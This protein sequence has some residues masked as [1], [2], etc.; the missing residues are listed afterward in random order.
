M[1]P[2]LLSPI[3]IGRHIFKN[4]IVSAP[5]GMLPVLP[6]FQMLGPALEDVKR[7]CRGGIAEFIV[8]ETPIDSERSR[9][10]A[11][12]SSDYTD[13]ES[14]AAR[15]FR[16][17]TDAMHELGVVAMIELNHCGAA[18]DVGGPGMNPIGP[19]GFIR[20]DGIEVEEMDEQMMGRVADNFATCV[21]F[22]QTV[23]F[24]GVIPHAGHGWLL[25]EFLSPLSNKRTDAYGG[26]IEGRARFPLMVLRRIREACGPD[27]LIEIRISGDEYMLI[28]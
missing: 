11:G 27:F 26:D 5:K 2:N 4:R 9:R 10:D 1:Y 6:E 19:T 13:Y 15:A 14:P 25:H 17:Y 28:R 23:G 12:Q 18:R 16:A 20:G 8:G 22:M 24:D 7:K 21:K 3:K